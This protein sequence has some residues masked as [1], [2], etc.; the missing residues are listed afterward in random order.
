[1]DRVMDDR[2]DGELAIAKFRA[3]L[4]Y[5]VKE[6]VLRRQNDH[7]PKKTE[8]PTEHAQ[9]GPEFPALLQDF[10]PDTF[11]EDD[12]AALDERMARARLVEEK[13]VLEKRV[14]ALKVEKERSHR[15]EKELQ[16]WAFFSCA[17]VIDS[18]SPPGISQQRF[19]NLQKRDEAP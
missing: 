15:N 12:Q 3:S 13:V 10:R 16:R 6:V 9:M 11:D 8:E 7:T 1:M 14:E 19:T 5:L 2:M 18:N 4:E 17:K